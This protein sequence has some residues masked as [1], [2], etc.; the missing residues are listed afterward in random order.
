MLARNVRV[1]RGEI[2][3]L[4]R[5]DGDL[6]A[7]EVKARVGTAVDPIA[8]FTPAKAARVRP[9]ARLLDPP[10]HRVDLVTVSFTK[11]GADVR[12]VPHAG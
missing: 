9:A 2:D 3:L 5:V 8:N 1:Q 10:V 11:G 4:V 6:V 7:V 12:W